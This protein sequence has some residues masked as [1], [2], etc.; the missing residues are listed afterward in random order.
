MNP[1]FVRFNSMG[2]DVTTLPT[3][4]VEFRRLSQHAFLLRPAIHGRHTNRTRCI[5]S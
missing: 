1:N 2:H 3:A 5:R 4:W